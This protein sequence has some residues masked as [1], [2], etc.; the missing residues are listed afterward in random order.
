MKPLI[1]SKAICDYLGITYKTFIRLTNEDETFPARMIR[2]VWRCD[3]DE[4]KEWFRNQKSTPNHN[5]IEI[6]KR[7]RGRPCLSGTAPKIQA[8]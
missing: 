5:V 8:N 7:R 4:L 6:S 1:N 3:E 2:S